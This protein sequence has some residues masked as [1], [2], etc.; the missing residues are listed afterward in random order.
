[1]YLEWC[2]TWDPREEI[3]FRLLLAGVCEGRNTRGEGTGALCLGEI[4]IEEP[5]GG[6][7]VTGSSVDQVRKNG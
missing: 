5:E 6:D 4:S 2:A 1:M 3:P 7:A